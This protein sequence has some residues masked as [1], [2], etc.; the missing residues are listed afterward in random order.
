MTKNEQNRVVAW[1]LKIIRQATELPRGVAQIC[2]HFGLSRKTYYKWRARYKSHGD[3][4][5]CDRPRAP[6]HFPRA[7]TRNVVSKILYLRERYR[8]GPA[9]INSYLHRF[10]NID[11]A[12]S[13]V[14]RILIRYGMNRLPANQK[15]QPTGRP[16]HRYEKPQPGH[17]LQIDVKFLER[18]A[19]SR[20]RLYQFTSEQLSLLPERAYERGSALHGTQIA[21]RAN[22]EVPEIASAVVGHS[23][24]L[25]VTP[26]AFDRIHLRGVGGQELQSEATALSLDV[27]AHESGA[28]RSQRLRSTSCADPMA[29]AFCPCTEHPPVEV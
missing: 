18:I 25:Q 3:A 12:R 6:L 29:A 4:G 7:T 13:T 14:H 20:K 16:W 26:H 28:V 9:R 17:R 27:F 8:F 23:V 1:R 21:A 2:R 5:L 15:R 10:H 11:V 19:G 24:V 22:G